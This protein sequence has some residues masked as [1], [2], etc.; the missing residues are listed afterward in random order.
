MHGQGNRIY[1]PILQKKLT[2]LQNPFNFKK[3][4]KSFKEFKKEIMFILITCKDIRMEM[5]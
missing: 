4:S 3:T 1:G 2:H 5:R